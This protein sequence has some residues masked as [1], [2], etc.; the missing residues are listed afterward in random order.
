MKKIFLI[1]FLFLIP[2]FSFGC[3]NG[4]SKVLKNGI[5]I[6]EDAEGVI[7]SG[8]Y[9]YEQNFPAL[10]KQLDSLYLKT[11]DLDYLSDK[12]YILVLQKKYSEALNL[13]LE[14][15][16]MQPNR[17]A[18]ASNIGTIYELIG[19]NKKAH[20][21]IS[22]AIKINP[23]SHEGSEWL[24]LKILETKIAD[25][26]NL[27]SDFLLN[28]TF[29][30]KPG[31]I[32]KLSSSELR[33]LEKSLYFQLNERISF[34]KGK[35]PII[36]L[37]LFELANLEIIRG[38]YYDAIAIYKMAKDYGFQNK[39]LDERIETAH[40]RVTESLYNSISE[41]EAVNNYHK[42]LFVA[43]LITSLLIVIILCVV[44]YNLKIKLRNY[45]E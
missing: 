44:I 45:K 15:E 30:E 24:H 1:G 35:D 39:L 4:A 25:L 14:I 13:Y 9:F 31:P 2:I 8:H 23:K 16:K 21:W 3:L 19:D 33:F 43:T 7:P 41:V 10:I 36:S 37:L 40:D 38:K 18:T 22:K 32:T 17:Y 6:Y 11:N 28:T 42:I 29:G 20:E 12:G 5:H 26:K 34:I 27:S